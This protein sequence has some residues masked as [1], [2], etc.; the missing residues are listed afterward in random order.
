MVAGCRC[1]VA[2]C[3]RLE[4]VAGCGRLEF[5]AGCRYL[6]AGCERLE[7]VPTLFSRFMI[8]EHTRRHG[9]L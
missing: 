9:R 1:W 7:V 5:V 2:G 3:E 4:V 8:H 6:V